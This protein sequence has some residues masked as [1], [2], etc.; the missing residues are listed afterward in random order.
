MIVLESHEIK[1]K[2]K[3]LNGARVKM[4]SLLQIKRQEL[5]LL[6][7]LLGIPPIDVSP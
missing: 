1:K 6:L 4:H 3:S 7:V 5:R 2:H